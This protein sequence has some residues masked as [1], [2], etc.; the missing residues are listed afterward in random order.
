MHGLNEAL[1]MLRKVVPCYSSTQKLSKIETLR[2]AKNYIS[3]LSEILS[4][5][6]VPDTV[7]FAQSLSKGLSQPTTNLVAGAMQLNPRTLMPDE[8]SLQYVGW[9]ERTSLLSSGH[10]Y[11]AMP[12]FGYSVGMENTLDENYNTA[13]YHTFPLD[14]GYSAETQAHAY[15]H[16]GD[17]GGANGDMSV[18]AISTSSCK[19][20][21]HTSSVVSTDGVISAFTPV[22][23]STTYPPAYPMTSSQNRVFQYGTVNGGDPEEVQ[24]QGISCNTYNGIVHCE[25]PPSSSEGADFDALTRH[26]DIV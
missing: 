22:V 15:Y 6:K 4:T 21:A 20:A 2:L 9:S 19:Y 24:N 13:P 25:T 7:T 18:N 8:P 14:G 3:A 26:R 5:G 23:N 11:P 1:D 12:Q 17:S 16:R 10:V